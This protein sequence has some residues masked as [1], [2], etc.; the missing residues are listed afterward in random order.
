M[1][2]KRAVCLNCIDG[3]VQL[4][5]IQWIKDNYETD[6]VDMITEPGIDGFLAERTNSM[7]E[8][9]TKV[10]ISIE[11]NKASIIFVVGHHDC[12][13]NPCSESDHRSQ[14]LLATNR[15]KKVFP[16]ET[17]VGL[18]VNSQWKAESL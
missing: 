11:K 12:K 4:P 13:G 17:V 5:V 6:Y 15:L 7:E 9:N 2:Q 16:E 1:V 3:R 18:W 10:R 14:I 8:I